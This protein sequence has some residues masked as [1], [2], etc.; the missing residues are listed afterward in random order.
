MAEQRATAAAGGRKRERVRTGDGALASPGSLRALAR[1]RNRILNRMPDDFD[2]ERLPPARRR[3]EQ[4]R[5]AEIETLQPQAPATARDARF[6]RLL[7]DDRDRHERLFKGNVFHV[8][9]EQLKAAGTLMIALTVPELFGSMTISEGANC[10][11]VEAERGSVPGRPT[12]RV[13]FSSYQ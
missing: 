3:H 4:D 11:H 7:F 9:D 12:T 2:D 6:K 1:R 10:T 5:L 13:F 8:A